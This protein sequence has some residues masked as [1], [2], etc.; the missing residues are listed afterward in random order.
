MERSPTPRGLGRGG[1]GAQPQ[2]G[3]SGAE[4]LSVYFFE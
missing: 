1:S 3:Y 2:R 4:P